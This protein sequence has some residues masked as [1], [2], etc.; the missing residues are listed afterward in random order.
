MPDEFYLNNFNPF[1]LSGKKILV[2]GA[3]SGIGQASSRLFSRLGGLVILIG[4]NTERLR[5]TYE[6]LA[7]SGHAQYNFDLAAVD[8]IP[9]LLKKI[10][11]DHGSLTGLFHV[12]GI[13][14]VKPLSL[15]K[16]RHIDPV[17]NISVKATLM[18][19]KGLC[20]KGLLHESGAS[21]LF[22]SS[23]AGCRGQTGMSIYSASKAAV[24]GAMRS[25]ACELAPKGIRVNA[26]ASGAV[27]TGMHEQIIKDL[28][29]A[30]IIAYRQKH[31]LGFGAPEDIA[32]AAAF[33]L[34]DASTWITG[35]T[36]T[37]D[38]GY[39]CF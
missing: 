3:S 23:V 5:K 4:R 15:I 10:H 28:S 11:S 7:G 34:S 39:S 38:G 8:D 22:M 37:V 29:E 31:L 13:L 18:L 6:S 20:Q 35:T 33:L 16:S 27:H 9:T 12:A 2:T 26:I 36:M 30:A 25:L 24:E 1:N 14:S 32:N 17:L 19:A 21:L